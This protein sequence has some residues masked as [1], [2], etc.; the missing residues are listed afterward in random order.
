[1]RDS[2]I[3]LCIK[4]VLF[5][6]NVFFWLIGGLI[7]CIGL[8]ARVAYVNENTSLTV[9]S[10]WDIDPSVIFIF[11]GAL[12]FFLGFCGCV[13]AL[14]ENICLLKFFSISLSIIFFVQLASSILG[15]VYRHKIK[16]LV[17]E[18][19]E[20]TIINYRSNANLQNIIDYSQE[21]FKCCGLRSYRDWQKNIYF[22]CSRTPRGPESC[23]VPHSCCQKDKLNTL[24]GYKA[25]S[26]EIS[27]QVRDETIYTRG[28]IDGIT[29][30]FSKHLEIAGSVGVGV[31]LLQM[32]TIGFATSLI[33]DIRR[34]LAKWSSPRGTHEM[35][36]PSDM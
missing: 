9:F 12:M 20:S 7:L 22:N 13:G 30:W 6:F 34:Q 3:S 21:T 18:K 36:F 8:W 4:Y 11:V 5:F 10:G 29:T 31:A 33:C 15:F 26:N 35:L 19:L 24:C 1:M 27:P 28:C 2:E 25:N 32:L 14:R 16:I 17:T 23:S